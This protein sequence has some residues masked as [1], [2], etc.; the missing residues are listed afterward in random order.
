MSFVNS[1]TNNKIKY[2]T[3][4]EII[5]GG[6]IQ[7]GRK[8]PFH[9]TTIGKH[10]RLLERHVVTNPAGP[11]RARDGKP[12]AIIGAGPVGLYTGIRLILNGFKII[13]IEGRKKYEREQIFFIQRSPS[14]R[15]FFELPNEIINEVMLES[16]AIVPPI[17]GRQNECFQIDQTQYDREFW[18]I[19]DNA[20]TRGIFMG[21]KISDFERILL[22]HFLLLGGKVIRPVDESSDGVSDAGAAA[23]SASAAASSASA[24]AKP[25]IELSGPARLDSK[26]R[27]VL[28]YSFTEGKKS[29]YTIESDDYDRIIDSSG[30]RFK[31]Y[32]K[33]YVTEQDENTLVLDTRISQPSDTQLGPDQILSYGLL[34][35]IDKRDEDD[36]TR[37]REAN[38]ADLPDLSDPSFVEHMVPGPDARLHHIIQHR[39]RAFISKDNIYVAIMIS[40]AEYEYLKRTTN[41]NIDD[42]GK[43]EYMNF[44]A[45]RRNRDSNTY[46]KYLIDSALY[47]YGMINSKNVNTIF[48]RIS[49]DIIPVSLS[50][51]IDGNIINIPEGRNTQVIYPIGDTALGV[52]FFSG[53]GV[54]YGFEM[55]DLLFNHIVHNTTYIDY[56]DSMNNLLN[57]ALE[58]STSFFINF[59]QVSI[60]EYFANNLGVTSNLASLP[61]DRRPYKTDLIRDVDTK[62][63]HGFT[64]R[65]DGRRF[66]ENIRT[67]YGMS[68]TLNELILNPLNSLRLFEGDY[69]LDQ[70]DTQRNVQ[71]REIL[72]ELLNKLY[73][74]VVNTFS[75]ERTGTHGQFGSITDADDIHVRYMYWVFNNMVEQDAHTGG[76]KRMDIEDVRDGINVFPIPTKRR[77]MRD[78]N[79]SY[80]YMMLLTIFAPYL[81]T[82]YN[83]TIL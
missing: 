75:H 43:K 68:E 44:I 53:S 9:E 5:G 69:R 15:A 20:N 47:Y 1:Y 45:D 73:F 67:V 12:I 22:K 28:D 38:F 30:G 59:N 13:L 6:F 52:N 48:N 60:Y 46:L 26:E 29:K 7:H 24:S 17:Y 3:L 18:S 23:A 34:I 54:N 11:A 10:I 77:M 81:E 31:S 61:H 37:F 62:K 41:G 57:R 78:L 80:L 19:Q 58:T 82:T 27:I 55:A 49:F 33:H 74:Y 32:N 40:K 25:P 21:I 66:I 63:L 50:R 56:N 70:L 79:T 39:F 51:V 65:Y 71:D 72:F 4:K 64:G 76:R 42:R 83:L 16:C 2:L 36:F 35:F 14:F 8:T